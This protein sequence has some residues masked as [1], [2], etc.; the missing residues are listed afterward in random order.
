M[1]TTPETDQFV[2]IFEANE[3]I[4]ANLPYPKCCEEDPEGE[5]HSHPDD[6]SE[7]LLLFPEKVEEKD[8]TIFT[9]SAIAFDFDFTTSDPSR[10]RADEIRVLLIKNRKPSRKSKEGKPGGFGLPTGQLES[11]EAMLHA[12]KRETEDES[13]CSVKKIVGKLFVIKKQIKIDGQPIPNEIHVFLIEASE[14]MRRVKESDEID[15]SVD[16]WIPLRQV[17]EMPMAQ[18]KGGGSKNP[19]GIYFSHLQRLYRAIECMVFF[20]E[21]LID[22]EA[23]KTWIEPNR[24]LLKSAMVDIEKAGLLK[25]FAPIEG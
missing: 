20:P 8:P 3:D 24:H 5:Y 16:P 2:D 22:G 11:R 18:D 14:S 23:I 25:R 17:F 7:Q 12:V 15:G 1:E 13:G 6:G 19:D 21:E 9:V 4:I 10:S